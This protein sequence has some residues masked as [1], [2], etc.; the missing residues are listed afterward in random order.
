MSNEQTSLE[1]K[2]DLMILRAKQEFNDV[3][4]YI[5]KIPRFVESEYQVELQKLSSYFPDE[6]DLA[7]IRWKLESRKLE[8]TFPFMIS[9]GNIFSLTSLFEV[10]MLMLAKEVDSVAKVE[11][12]KTRGQGINKV[13]SFLKTCNIELN[14]LILWPQIDAAIKIRNC[15]MHASGLL[16]WSRDEEE[17]RR[18][19][20]SSVF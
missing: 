2:L 13:F 15:L 19:V 12:N 1:Q 10:Y 7:K 18:I 20:K 11:L 8:A 16:D 17:L 3:G 5:W 14:K 4:D 6:P 9:S